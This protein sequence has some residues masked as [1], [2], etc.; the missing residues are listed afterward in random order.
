M[1]IFWSFKL[2]LSIQSVIQSP[3]LVVKYRVL[4][5]GNESKSCWKSQRNGEANERLAST[6]SCSMATVGLEGQ[7]KEM[8]FL[9]TRSWGHPMGAEA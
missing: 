7:Q 5:L 9:E 6:G 3:Q 1:R 8:I 4:I 2:F